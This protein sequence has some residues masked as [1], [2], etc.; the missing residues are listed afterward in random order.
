MYAARP[1]IQEA[2]SKPLDDDYFTQTLLPDYIRDRGVDWD[3]VFDDRGHFRE[4]TG[5]EIGLGT[6]AV[7]RYIKQVHEPVV[8]KST[9]TTPS[10]KLLG[11]S[12]NYS[13]ALFFEKEGF[14]HLLK[15]VNLAQRF[16]IAV[17]STKG[18]SVTAAR[19]LIADLCKRGVRIFVLHDFDKS[20]FSIAST[21]QRDTRR[22]QFAT[23][24]RLVD[25]GLRMDDVVRLGLE[26]N[27]EQVNDLGKREARA[28]N[29]RR[30][31]ATEQEVEFLLDRRVELNALTSDQFVAFIETK[32]REHGVEKVIPSDQLLQEQ[33]AA[34]RRHKAVSARFEE[35]MKREEATKCPPLERLRERVAERLKANPILRWHEAVAAIARETDGGDA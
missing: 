22:Y 5:Y 13:S 12:G 26:D 34:E 27:A 28:K 17:M 30:N 24:L 16:D 35:A 10:V 2:T 11:H 33:Y 29:L 9:I 25:L 19:Q 23:Q 31:G 4:P 1:H 15:H 8:V 3:I 32:L 20:G 21:L 7:R 18:M 6:L 14:D